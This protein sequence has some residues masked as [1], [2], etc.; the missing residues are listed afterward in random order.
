MAGKN[1]EKKPKKRPS[2]K[3]RE[4]RAKLTASY[5]SSLGIGMII[6]GAARPLLDQAAQTSI[7]LVLVAISMTMGAFA[8]LVGRWILRGMENRDGQ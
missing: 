4:E 3:V 2:G 7:D 1:K 8:H 5:V 6:I